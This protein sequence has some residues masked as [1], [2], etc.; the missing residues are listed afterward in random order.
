MTLTELRKNIASWFARIG[1]RLLKEPEPS[2]FLLLVIA[3]MYSYF[4]ED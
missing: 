4:K 1:Q 2:I 3:M